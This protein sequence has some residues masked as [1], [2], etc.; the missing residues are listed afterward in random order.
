MT[1][2]IIVL[3]TS[4]VVFVASF[5]N[6]TRARELELAAFTWARRER[7]ACERERANLLDRLAAA[8]DRP[9]TPAPAAMPAEL[10]PNQDGQFDIVAAADQMLHGDGAL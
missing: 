8:L 1:G 2:A 5:W 6:L 9:W 4:L 7:E 10:P 3:A